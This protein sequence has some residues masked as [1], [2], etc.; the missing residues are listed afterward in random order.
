MSVFE[1]IDSKLFEEIVQHLKT[2]TF[3][4]DTLPTSFLKS[5]LNCLEADLLEMVNALLLSGTLP[6]SLKT[7]VVKSLLKK[8]N[9][10]NTIL[11]NY[12]PI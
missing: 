1:E 2:S 8:C 9:H 12:R 4:L 3:Y 10:D 6:Y 11:S 7:A 5:V